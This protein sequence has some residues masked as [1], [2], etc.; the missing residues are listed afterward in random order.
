VC[1]LKSFIA[2]DL[3]QM[4][5]Q[6]VWAWRVLSVIKTLQGRIVVHKGSYHNENVEDLMR[7]AEDVKAARE[8]SLWEAKHVEGRSHNVHNSTQDPIVQVQVR[9]VP[10]A[11]KDAL[12]DERD[13]CEET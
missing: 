8:E 13:G 3:I 4:C 11:H 7:R 10:M 12:M 9:Q 6:V 5:D 2:A 1:H